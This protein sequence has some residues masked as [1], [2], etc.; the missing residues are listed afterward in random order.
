MKLP[1]ARALNQLR[2]TDETWQVAIARLHIRVK[3]PDGTPGQPYGIFVISLDEDLMLNVDMTESAP[4][5]DQVL[6][7]IFKAMRKPPKNA[8]PA[9]R[10]QTIGLP[11]RVLVDALAAQ[12]AEIDVAPIEQQPPEEFQ[13]VIQM[14]E[15]Q[16]G[17]DEPEHPGLLTVKGATPEFIGSLFAAAAD[18][19][20][21]EP[22]VHLDNYQIIALRQPAERDFHF[23][24][25]M[26]NG[27]V[28]YGLALYRTWADAEHFFAGA[29]DPLD[30]LPESG[31]RSLF[32]DEV[33]LLPLE[34]VEAI[35]QYGWEIANEQA[36]P[37]P[38][39]FDKKNGVQRPDL[40]ELR[41]YEAALRAI[42]IFVRDYLKPDGQGDYQP[43]AAS[44]EV[45]THA[46]PIKVEVKYP[47][48]EIR[49]DTQPAQENDWED[50]D[51]DVEETEEPP[52]FDRRAMEGTLF[53][54]ITEEFGEVPG[55]G[56]PDLDRAQQIMYQAW[57]ETNP[58]KR[59]T[60]AHQALATSPDCA[61]AYV[62][63][64][65]E[66]ADTVGRALELYQ[67][68]VAAGER[69]LGKEYFEENVGMFWGILET[70][71]YMRA[72]EGL[73]STLWHLNRK[74]EAIEHYLEML[75]L[76]EGDN[77]GVRYMLADLLL[78]TNRYDDL[79][80]LLHRY[81]D[82]ASAVW[83]YTRALLNFH[84]EGKSAKADKALKVALKE[85][86]HVPD[87]LIGKKRIPNRLP[88]YMG[89]GDDDEAVHYAAS[90]L[91]YWRREPG[92]I[93]WLTESLKAPAVPKK[94]K[95]AA[96]ASAKKTK[97]AA[98]ASAKKKPKSK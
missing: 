22:W 25:I 98:A 8:G 56:N 70:R 76:N 91:N 27:G 77:Q 81:E 33:E 83:L 68:G 71:P 11:D 4:A 66:E 53:K 50:F 79:A 29:D 94:K 67:Q 58:G 24:S 9:R 28:E 6:E 54:T 17:G 31:A 36:Y 75:R 86:R 93:E 63:L 15:K 38:V 51:E 82:E 88:A 73:A 90:H 5:P 97:P 1:S 87:Y 26:G 30:A 95:P 96:A 62:L 40:M 18:F 47:A 78:L 12:L 45:P 46:G 43:I 59:L 35:Q 55:S 74:D 7:I 60:L 39:V 41:W 84:L 80:G 48:G 85:N 20:R 44:I 23:T 13:E 52:Y 61:D 3:L 72:R 21:A 19:Y 14:F 57:D 42:P 49:R 10:P 65:E 89:L 64:A 92:A 2:Q 69:A 16:F 32:F 34:D 37:M